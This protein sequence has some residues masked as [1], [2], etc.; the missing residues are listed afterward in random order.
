MTGVGGLLRPADVVRM[1]KRFAVI[2]PAFTNLLEEPSPK[3]ASVLLRA[4]GSEHVVPG[5]AGDQDMPG[6]ASM[7]ENVEAWEEFKQTYFT[8]LVEFHERLTLKIERF[9]EDLR[10]AR[11]PQG[12]SIYGRPYKHRPYLVEVASR[13]KLDEAYTQELLQRVR[14]QAPIFA[15]VD[16][17]ASMKPR[18]SRGWAPDCQCNTPWHQRS[19][20]E[21]QPWVAYELPDVAQQ[22]PCRIAAAAVPEPVAPASGSAM[23]G[24]AALACDLPLAASGRF[25]SPGHGSM[26][27]KVQQPAPAPSS[28]DFCQADM[29]ETCGAA[30]SADL[31]AWTAD[32]ED[33]SIDAS[34][35]QQSGDDEV[36]EGSE[37]EDRSDVSAETAG[38]ESLDVDPLESG[39]WCDMTPAR[40][41]GADTETPEKTEQPSR[42]MLNDALCDGQEDCSSMSSDACPLPVGDVLG[43]H[44][45]DNCASEEDYC[46]ESERY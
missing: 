10:K 3:K 24:D 32:D 37:V 19:L 12:W 30:K 28:A 18:F 23:Q 6:S 1:A 8:D 5:V 42:A 2:A 46:N 27:E 11:A 14:F 9:Q 45:S 26:A 44:S 38:S 40:K 16:D 13:T 33:G 20:W 22:L 17:D 43:D 29:M 31:I 21:R 4:F 41:H 25:R 7:P 36:D 35:V 39:S 34:E 15:L